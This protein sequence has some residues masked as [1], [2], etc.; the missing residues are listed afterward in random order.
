MNNYLGQHWCSGL[1]CNVCRST[2]N[3]SDSSDPNLSYLSGST[4]NP[5]LPLEYYPPPQTQQSNIYDPGPL[6]FSELQTQRSNT[7]RPGHVPPP[8]NSLN[9]PHSGP[10]GLMSRSEQSEDPNG[11]GGSVISWD[12]DNRM[13][14]RQSE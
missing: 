14:E 11:Y 3:L 8:S 1:A 13:M 2:L 6:Q 10:I 9:F 5:L 7:N 4:I 12:I